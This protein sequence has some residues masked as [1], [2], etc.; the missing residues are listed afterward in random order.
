M[1]EEPTHVRYALVTRP[2]HDEK[3]ILTPCDNLIEAVHKQDRYD[4]IAS[5]VICDDFKAQAVDVRLH[6]I[7]GPDDSAYRTK[8]MLLASFIRQNNGWI[9]RHVTGC[10]IDAF[11]D[12]TLTFIQSLLS[13]FD[14]HRTNFARSLAS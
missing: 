7:T 1:F 4:S 10:M 3:V 12:E 13:F 6:F 8:E 14:S 11:D 5:V 2:Q 9:P